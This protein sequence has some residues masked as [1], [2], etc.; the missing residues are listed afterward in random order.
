MADLKKTLNDAIRKVHELKEQL[1]KAKDKAGSAR[2]AYLDSLADEA[3]EI[4]RSLEWQKISGRGARTERIAELDDNSRLLKIR[5]DVSDLDAFD[6]RGLEFKGVRLS[7]WESNR[8]AR[9]STVRVSIEDLEKIG[10]VMPGADKKQK[11]K[12]RKLIEK[13]GLTAEQL[14]KLLAKQ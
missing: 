3:Y 14:E 10:V 1:G 2:E 13:S 11:A 12:M 9:N 5:R 8:Y 7:V 6:F 4:L